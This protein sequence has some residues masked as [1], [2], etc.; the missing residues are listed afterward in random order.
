MPKNS[1]SR[2]AYSQKSYDNMKL[3]D[4]YGTI[5]YTERQT[6]AETYGT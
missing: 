1:K 4:S 5:D 6:Q 2:N 3:G